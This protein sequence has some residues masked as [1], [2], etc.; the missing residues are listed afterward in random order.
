MTPEVAR[1]VSTASL[2]P[3]PLPGYVIAAMR[4]GAARLGSI[5]LL[6]AAIFCA[7]FLTAPAQAQ[8]GVTHT[9]V[10]K[11]DETTITHY[12]VDQR[13]R[14]LRFE[15]RVKNM[16]QARK[17][18]REILIDEAL[19]YQNIKKNK[20]IPSDEDVNKQIEAIAKGTVGSVKKLFKDL[21]AAGINPSTFKNRVRVQ[22]GWGELLQKRHGRKIR[23]S[24]QEVADR[25]KRAPKTPQG[26]TVYRVGQIMVDT[27]RNALPLQLAVAHQ[28]A[29]KAR[30]EFTS[31][32]NVP[33]LAKKYSKVFPGAVGETVKERMPPPLQKVILPLKP[34]ENTQ[35]LRTAQ[36]FLIFRLCDRKRTGGKKLGKDAVERMLF[37]EKLSQFTRLELNDMRRDALIEIAQ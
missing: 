25:L 26:P 17:Q 4:F 8:V 11:V 15:G 30:K 2:K 6:C 32:K 22:L 21:K 24:E 19:Q 37:Q 33:Q 23:P 16:A 9:W 29:Q 12:D 7:M 34:G 1:P 27:P 28:Q 35:P 10:A 13:A 18:A 5:Q 36:G 14:L 3:K 20:A 31:C